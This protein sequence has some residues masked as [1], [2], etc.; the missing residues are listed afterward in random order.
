[1]FAEIPVDNDPRP[2][3]AAMARAGT[4]AKIRTGGVTPDAFPSSANIVRFM[5]RCIDAGVRFKATAGL[6]HPLRADFPL[7]Y[8]TSSP[9][10]VMFG[11]LNVFLAAAA[12]AQGLSDD[13]A[14][15]ILEETDAASIVATDD[16]L[17]WRGITLSG[18]QLVRT[19][20]RVA[21][22]FG[23]CSFREPVDELRSLSLVA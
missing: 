3:V 8:E 7:T 21:V 11:Y 5:R 20:V 9:R 22:S 13:D 10:G 14:C 17:I 18:E 23:S 1:L 16:A 15:R 6:H 12:V 19:R 2:L 4:S